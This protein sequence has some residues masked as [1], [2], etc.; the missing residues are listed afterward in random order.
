MSAVLGGVA[1]S[2]GSRVLLGALVGRLDVRDLVRTTT[3]PSSVGGAIPVYTQYLGVSGQYGIS[4]AQVAVL[5]RLHQERFD[6]L[7]ETGVT[8][9]L[10]VRVHPTSRLTIAGATHFLPADL[11][12]DAATDYYLGVDYEILP[13]VP[14][15]TVSASIAGRYGLTFRRSEYEHALGVGMLLGGRLRL[16]AAVTREVGYDSHSLRPSI[17]LS[18]VLGR[19]E[20][21]LAR[22][23]GINDL[24]AT[25]RVGLNASIAK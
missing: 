21:G 24:G 9:D 7:S 16:D 19:Y 8:F 18:L 15:G 20:I 6:Y 4:L 12:F 25:Y 23:S 2:L 3:S 10:G 13:T 14:I 1:T 11:S 22:S 17:G 5:A